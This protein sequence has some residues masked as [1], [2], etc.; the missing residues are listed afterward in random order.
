MKNRFRLYLLISF[1][2]LPA[3]ACQGQ[4]AEHPVVSALSEVEKEKADSFGALIERLSGEP[5]YFDTDNLISNESS[6]LHVIGDLKKLGLSGGAYL[7]VGPD[8]NFSYIAHLRPRVVVIVDVRRDNMLL[9]LLYKALFEMSE[10]R[11][12][13]LANLFGRAVPDDRDV[14]AWDIARVF[15]A[16]DETHVLDE[17]DKV[18]FQN[19]ILEKVKQLGVE[20]SEEDL[21]KIRRFHRMFIELGPELRFTSHGRS[22]QSYYPTYRQLAME[23]DR[24]SKQVSFLSEEPLF[25]YLKKLQEEDRVIPVTGNFAAPDALPEIGAYLKEIGE[26]VTAFYTSNVEYYLQYQQ[27]SSMFVANVKQLPLAENSVIIRSYFN[28]FRM[29]HPLSKPGYGS[30]QLLQTMDS[31]IADPDASYGNLVFDRYLAF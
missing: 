3:W 28:R 30:T 7:G 10:N 25:Q 14:E 23:T 31:F 5:G 8:Q 15:Q 2:I 9:H 22:P 1:L 4:T 24:E 16:I 27:S 13:F 21:L 17:E 11:V 18:T 19:R 20:F 6:Y 26:A 29:N 12:T